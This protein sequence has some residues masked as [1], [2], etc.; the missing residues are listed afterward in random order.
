MRRVRGVVLGA[1]EGFF[2]GLPEGRKE[3]RFELRSGLPEFLF[4]N[5]R[6]VQTDGLQGRRAKTRQRGCAHSTSRSALR[7]PARLMA[8]KMAMT[9]RAVAPMVCKPRMSS[10][11]VAP[12]FSCT[13]WRGDSCAF[14]VVSG[15]TFVSPVFEKGAGWDT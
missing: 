14:T 5:G 1:G 6:T 7:A 15:T 4:L 2:H 9:S 13:A 8:C 12:S 11:T 10:S 3:D